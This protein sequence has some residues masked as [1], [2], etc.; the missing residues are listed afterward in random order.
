MS[1]R[2]TGKRKGAEGV[3]ESTRGALDRSIVSES[4]TSYILFKYSQTGHIEVHLGT[5][6]PEGPNI[7]RVQDHLLQMLSFHSVHL[8]LV[9]RNRGYL[10]TLRDCELNFIPIT[11]VP[12]GLARS[13]VRAVVSAVWA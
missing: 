9:V 5:T 8:G 13:R 2:L 7:A 4:G 6:E 1:L 11:R 12:S 3:E 10:E